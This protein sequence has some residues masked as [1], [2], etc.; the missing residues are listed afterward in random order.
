MPA[1]TWASTSCLK[2]QSNP[3]LTQKRREIV[4]GPRHEPELKT[5]SSKVDHLDGFSKDL[6][7]TSKVLA[8]CLP[9]R[10]SYWLWFI[11]NLESLRRR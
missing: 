1:A 9:D 3:T 11:G 6:E 2:K 5:A 4:P 10:A 7:P 8:C